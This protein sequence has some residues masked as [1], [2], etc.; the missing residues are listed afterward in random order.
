MST[1]DCQKFDETNRK[2]VP[3]REVCPCV[4]MLGGREGRHVTGFLDSK[5]K[6]KKQCS[7]TAR[8]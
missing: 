5:T 1:V 2:H 3:N 4:V 7:P 8:L 6:L